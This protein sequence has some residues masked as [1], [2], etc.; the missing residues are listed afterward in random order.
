M[1]IEKDGRV[2]AGRSVGALCF[3]PQASGGEERRKRILKSFPFHDFTFPFSAI[4]F[5]ITLLT[6]RWLDLRVEWLIKHASKATGDPQQPSIQPP[7]H[8]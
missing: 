5:T 6:I 1:A 8:R 2:D 3:H 4:T 7:T